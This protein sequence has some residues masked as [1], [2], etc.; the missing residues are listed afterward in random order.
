MLQGTDISEFRA[1]GSKCMA[2]VTKYTADSL[3][4]TADSQEGTIRCFIIV[5]EA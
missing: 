1:D 3:K 5:P 4:C 2:D